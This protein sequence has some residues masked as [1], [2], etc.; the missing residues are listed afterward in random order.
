RSDRDW[1]SDVCSSDLA[2]NVGVEGCIHRDAGTGIIATAAK[3]RRITERGTGGT[4]LRDEGVQ[5]PAQA[6]IEGSSGRREVGRFGLTCH[7]GIAQAIQG[8]GKAF[9]GVGATQVG[10]VVERSARGI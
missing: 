4:Y 7:I 6:R 1:S 2:R 9:V 10:Q 8:D 3:V 5:G